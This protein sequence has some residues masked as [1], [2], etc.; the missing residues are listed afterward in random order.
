MTAPADH[1]TRL[2]P[3]IRIM[4]AERV[5]PAL[6]DDAEQEARIAVWTVATAHADDPRPLGPLLTTVA[7]RAVRAVAVGRPMTGEEGRRGVERD[8]LR[9][10]RLVE[11]DTERDDAPQG[12]HAE[13]VALRVSVARA[14][15][16]L[17]PWERAYVVGR[18]LE[19][20]PVAE[21]AADLGMSPTGLANA[22][23]RRLRPALAEALSPLVS[24]GAQTRSCAKRFA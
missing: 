10:G 13:A 20:R 3:L 14:L 8:P 5:P 2:D 4:S 24:A 6:R 16:D 18:F 7:R 11:L 9:A 19:D 22:W 12:D 15:A 21:V 1:V 23:S 17:A